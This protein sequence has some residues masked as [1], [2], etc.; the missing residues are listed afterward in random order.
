[1]EPSGPGLS[2]VREGRARKPGGSSFSAGPRLAAPQAVLRVHPSLLA[3]A[4]AACTG[5]SPSSGPQIE[6]MGSARDCRSDCRAA[7]AL[8]P[9]VSPEDVQ[10]ATL[11]SPDEN[12]LGA[13]LGLIQR[14]VEA[15]AADPAVYPEG[16]NPFSIRYAVYNLAHP[17]LLEALAGAEARGVD[18]QILIED[19][20]LDPGRS[21]N[22]ADELLVARGF[23]LVRDHRD[24]DDTTRRTADLIGVVGEGLMHLKTR[25]YSWIDPATGLGAVRLVTGSMN[26][27]DLAVF[28]DETLH[29]ISIPEIAARYAAKLDALLR[30]E[31]VDN[32]WVDGAPAQVLFSPDPGP[33]AIDQIARLIDGERELIVV[34]VFTLRNPRPRAGGKGLLDRLID[35]HARGVPVVVLTDR[36]QSDGVDASGASTGTNDGGEDALRAA[37][38]PVYEVMNRDHSPYNAMHTKYAVFGL[39]HPVVVTDAGNWTRAAFGSG[40]STPVNDESVL[41]LGDAL[42]DG[43]TARRTLGHFLRMLFRYGTDGTDGQ[44]PTGGPPPREVLDLLAALPGWPRVEVELQAHA[45]TSWGQSLAVAGDAAALGAWD[46]AAALP[47][48][49]DASSY[50]VWS[51]ASP[52][53]LPLGDRVEAKLVRRATGGAT[54]WEA[55]ENRRLQIDPTVPGLGGGDAD[56]RRMTVR[57]QW[58]P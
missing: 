37:G 26:P 36:K 41:F 5:I 42:D 35:A 44:T 50:P 34:A 31:E 51:A 23:E 4:A 54:S 49:T 1:M 9:V 47:L 58:R 53:V 32:V 17:A 40:Q 38:I 46:P 25:L 22:T 20:Q 56:G 10:V 18:V 27:G 14:V 6:G 13:D 8:E 21:Y 48:A 7:E 29:V 57:M 24:L 28:N 55:G 30:G 19:E 3:L 39:T 33:Q 12:P 15:R 45:E 2:C 16:Q 11:F 52:L 43:R